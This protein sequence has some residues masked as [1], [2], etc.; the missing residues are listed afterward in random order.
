MAAQMAHD[1]RS[2]DA[3]EFMEICYR[4]WG[5]VPRAAVRIDAAAPLFVDPADVRMRA[6]TACPRKRRAGCWRRPRAA[7]T[8]SRSGLVVTAVPKVPI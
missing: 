3:D 1:K 7:P 6:W 2:D 8:A 4:L 5:S